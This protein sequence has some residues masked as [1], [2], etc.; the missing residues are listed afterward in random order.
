[1]HRRDSWPLDRTMPRSWEGIWTATLLLVA[2]SA[3]AC[4]RVVQPDAGQ[5]DAARCVPES[6]ETFCARQAAG[7]AC[8]MHSELDNCGAQRSAD[9]GAC[10]AGKGC[11]VGECRTPACTSFSYASSTLPAFSRAGIEDGIAATTPD[12]QTIVYIQTA[13]T[14]TCG[15]FHVVLADEITPGSGSFM[16]NDATTALQTLQLFAGQ[17]GFAITADGLTLVARSAN[18]K[19]ML[20]TTRSARQKVDFATPTD[21]DFVNINMQVASTPGT[22]RAPVLSADRLEIFYRV[23]SSDTAERG[24]YASVRSSTSSPFPAGTKQPSPVGDYEFPTGLSS[25]RLTLFLFDNFTGRVLQRVSTSGP[26]IN[27]SAPAPPPQVAGWEH[28]PLAD[29]SKLLAITTPG[30]CAGEDVSL[31][32]RQ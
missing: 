4:G 22:F 26:F 15:S 11:V 32:T 5:S 3:F 13:M 18:S 8:E 14:A 30:G 24:I 25:D 10:A 7:A 17:E 12:G 20:A 29:C 28:K 27:P 6:D 31:L 2:T 21:E 16:Q 23:E 1:M 9:C 19:R